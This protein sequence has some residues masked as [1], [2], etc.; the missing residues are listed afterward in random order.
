LSRIAPKTF[1]TEDEFVGWLQTKVSGRAPGLRLGIG[2]DAALV[3]SAPGRQ[4]ILTTDLSVEDV[5]FTRRTHPP[6]SIGHRALARSLSDVAAMGG[7]P[8]FTLISLAISPDITRLWI[9]RFYEGLSK[10]AARYRT[11]IVGGDTA[12]NVA[13]IFADVAVLG[14]VPRG[15][16][17]RRSGTR[18]GDQLFVSGRLGLSRLGLELLQ[19]GS[20]GALERRRHGRGWRGNRG[21]VAENPVDAHLYPQPRCALGRY[22]SAR[23]LVSAAVDLSDGLSTDL[24][25]L[26][27]ASGVGARVWA[28]RIPGPEVSPPARSLELALHGGEDYELLIAVPPRNL[29]RIPARVRG[30]RLHHIGEICKSK[31]VLLVR[32]DGKEVPLRP[33]G[34]DHFRKQGILYR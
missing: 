27:Q 3:E 4:L 14:E 26:C 7:T 34:W 12:T 24:N 30:L 13:R 20:A 10:L 6:R 28:G 5:H 29:S 23:R 32:L 19:S 25:R 21:N 18:P 15:E 31:E 8:R 2:D 1:P 11:V 33:G 17:L 16:A 9:R 22:L